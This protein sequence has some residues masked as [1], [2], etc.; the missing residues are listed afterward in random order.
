MFQREDTA[1]FV[2][3]LFRMAG[4]QGGRVALLT[5]GIVDIMGDPATGLQVPG[6]ADAR[7]CM[8]NAGFKLLMRNDSDADIELITRTLGMTPSEGR[9]MKDAKHGQ[10]ILIIGDASVGTRR[11]YL[12]VYIPPLLYPWITTKPEEVE[13]FRQQGVFRAIES[14]EEE[15]A[16]ADTPLVTVGGA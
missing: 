2:S 15:A 7:Y 6:L 14:L 8:E 5:Q 4:K 1:K 13:Y 12:R 3:Q 9:V 16:W 11:A 10:G